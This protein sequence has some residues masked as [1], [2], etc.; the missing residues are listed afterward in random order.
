MAD[1]DRKQA[2]A[3]AL[4]EALEREPY[5][6]DF[7]QAMRSLECAFSDK[8]RLG[9]SDRAADDPI[10]VGQKPELAFAP[11]SIASFKSSKDGKPPRLEVL[12]FGLFGPNGPLPLHLTEYARDRS[13]N[14]ND[15]TL[16]RFADLFH[17]R[18]LSLLYRAWANAQPAV[19]FDR[20]DEDRFGV[21][22]GSLFGMGMPSV[23]S[24]DALSDLT[25]L[26]YAGSLAC[27]SRHAGGL[28]GVLAGFF[29]MPIEIEQF[30]GQWV[31]LPEDCQLRLGESPRTGAL[32]RT[33]TVGARIWECQQKFRIRF[34]PLRLE[35]YQCLLPGSDGLVRLGTLVRSYN[36]EELTWDVNLVL[37]KEDVPPLVLG[38]PEKLGWTTW[39]AGP[40]RTHDAAD[41]FLVASAGS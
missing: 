28:Q 9:Q 2:Y 14:S 26:H 21:Y 39:L 20:P 6:F 23:R 27:Q 16:I 34:G 1:P 13:R 15:P 40:P 35:D 17:H 7:Y 12:F 32:G 36:G 8:P 4:H 5:A 22:I 29:D 24:R 38:G 30:V 3:L 33:T 31:D 10:R 11:S 18:M 41:L 25:R 19:S 37:M